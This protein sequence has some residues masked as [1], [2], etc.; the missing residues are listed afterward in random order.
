MEGVEDF[1]RKAYL[2]VVA[3]RDP[4]IRQLVEDG[5]DFVTNAF[6]TGAGPTALRTKDAQAVSE[7]LRRAGF[8]V[9]LGAA[10][11]EAGE[12]LPRMRSVWRKRP[13]TGGA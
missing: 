4:A 1:G 5:Y 9:A 6:E 10:Y 13:T 12:P 7:Q 11:T 2:D 3:S 8:L